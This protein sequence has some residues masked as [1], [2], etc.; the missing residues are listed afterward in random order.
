LINDAVSCLSPVKSQILIP[1]HLN[2]LIAF[3]TPSCNLSS[4]AFN[5]HNIIS[6]LISFARFEI[7]SSRSSSKL[8]VC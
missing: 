3:G 7:A 8:V 2:I 6:V 5:P 1:E 4:T